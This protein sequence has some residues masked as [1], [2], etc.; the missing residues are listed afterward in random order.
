MQLTIEIRLAIA[1]A[2]KERLLGALDLAE[3][4]GSRG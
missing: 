1:A 3:Q 2:G 4:G